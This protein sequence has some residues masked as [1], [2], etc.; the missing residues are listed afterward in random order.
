MISSGGSLM[1]F[2][3]VNSIVKYFVVRHF[4]EPWYMISQ[5]VSRHFFHSVHLAVEWFKLFH[6]FYFSL[7]GVK[8]PF[9]EVIRAN[10]GDCH[11]MGQ[12]YIKF[13]RDVSIGIK[14]HLIGF[15]Q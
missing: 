10:I 2:R 6:K 1:E 14:K 12:P 9:N 11:A 4:I 15:S 13:L 5:L 3:I 8:K 7:Q